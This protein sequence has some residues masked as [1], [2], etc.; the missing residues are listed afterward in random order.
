MTAYFETHWS[1]NNAVATDNFR[2]F[3][4]TAPLGLGVSS[5]HNVTGLKVAPFTN[6]IM[7]ATVSTNS[8]DQAFLT[9][10][11]PYWQGMHAYV[12]GKQ[13]PLTSVNGVAPLVSLPAGLQQAELSVIYE[14][15][16]M[17]YFWWFIAGA[18]VLFAASVTLYRR[19]KS[20]I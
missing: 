20:A 13:V 8:Q 1:P 3:S 5:V 18:L 6:Q 2:S 11:T 16:T 17:T 15:T 10:A 19:R 4:R 9:L 14:T 12:N 7:N